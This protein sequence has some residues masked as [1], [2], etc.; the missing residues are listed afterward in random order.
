M[1][2]VNSPEGHPGGDVVAGA[3]GEVAQSPTRPPNVEQI[4]ID[5]DVACI[6]IEEAIRTTDAAIERGDVFSQEEMEDWA[7][8]VDLSSIPPKQK[9]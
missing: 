5:D 6:D 9:R 8:T 2:N 1:R 3:L 7:E 4:M